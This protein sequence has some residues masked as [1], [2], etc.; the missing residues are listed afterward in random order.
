MI[1]GENTQHTNPPTLVLNM[2]MIPLSNMAAGFL[3]ITIIH[4]CSSV[5]GSLSLLHFGIIES[6]LLN[7]CIL[8]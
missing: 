3:T 6:I 8:A 2:S 4:L 1:F 7:L 5:E